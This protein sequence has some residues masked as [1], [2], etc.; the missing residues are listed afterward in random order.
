ML[1]MVRSG[2]RC[3]RTVARG[4][5]DQSMKDAGS[6]SSPASVAAAAQAEE[7]NSM[8]AAR[9][10]RVLR[11]CIYIPQSGS[12][13]AVSDCPRGIHLDAAAVSVRPTGSKRSR[14]RGRGGKM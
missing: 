2:E 4:M 1:A 13:Q 6:K 14:S 10:R 11:H 8:V 12:L 5:P 3:H 9:T 7:R